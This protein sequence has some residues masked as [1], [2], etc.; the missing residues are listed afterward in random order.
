LALDDAKVHDGQALRA[1]FRAQLRGQIGL[2]HLV[3]AGF[4]PGGGQALDQPFGALRPAL[5][6][7]QT[8]NDRRVQPQ[9]GQKLE[10]L[11]Q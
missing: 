6:V 5:R 2:A 11:H 9:V 7:E 3:R 4:H 1:Q 10:L 8:E